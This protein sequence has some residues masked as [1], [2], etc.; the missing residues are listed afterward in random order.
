MK[1]ACPLAKKLKLL[2]AGLG[3]KRIDP[4]EFD[5]EGDPK[6]RKL[7]KA[8]VR[9]RFDEN[10]DEILSRQKKSSKRFH[11]KKTLKDELWED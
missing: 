5:E 3:M 7:G 9:K 6:E 2:W 11:R 4:L 1:S 10:E 8:K